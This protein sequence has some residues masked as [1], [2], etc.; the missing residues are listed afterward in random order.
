MQHNR[1][2]ETALTF[3]MP[4]INIIY[5]LR[6][7]LVNIN[8]WLNCFL[9]FLCRLV[10]KVERK[11]IPTRGGLE[12]YVHVHVYPPHSLHYNIYTNNYVH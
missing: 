11:C 8:K 2:T 4:I 12:G 9:R 7:I 10:L 1:I 6:V 3:P 5:A